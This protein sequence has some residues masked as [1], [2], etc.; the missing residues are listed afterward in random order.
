M[1][2]KSRNVTVTLVL[3][4]LLPSVFSISFEKS[5]ILNP[6]IRIK[7]NMDYSILI[8]SFQNQNS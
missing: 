4:C 6:I 2:L 7:L 1:Y 5:V 3:S 8:V